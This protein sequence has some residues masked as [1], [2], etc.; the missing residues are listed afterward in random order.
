MKKKTI[1]TALLALVGMTAMAQKEI[2]WQNPSA[3]MGE[4]SA[5][6]KV[7]KVELKETETV[8]HFSAKYA[9]H[10]WIRFAKESFLRTPDGKKY[11]VTSGAKTIEGESDLQLDS[12]F[13]M[14]DSGEAD[15]ALH[16]K[17][18]PLDTKE[19]DFIEGYDEG[20][21]RFWNICDE[22]NKK[23]LEIPADW[24][25][26][27]YAKDETLPAAKINKGVAT[28]KVKM[29][30]YKPD[31]KMEFY[32][33]G[34]VPLESTE[35]MDKLFPFAD[36]GTLKVEIPLWLT[37]EVT[38]GVE[39]IS[40]PHIMI[41]PGQET[42]ILMKVTDDHRPFLA[43]KGFL[44]KT[45]MDLVDA[46]DMHKSFTDD[47]ETFLKV[48]ECKTPDERLRCLTDIFNQ[49]IAAIEKTKYTT[50]AKDLLSM[51]V[52][53]N[54][55]RWTHLFASTF[56]QYQVGEDGKV[57]RTFENFEEN[58]KKCMD[59]LPLSG[60]AAAYSWKYLNEPASPCSLAFWYTTIDNF[61]KNA[62]EKNAYNVELR[63]IPSVLGSYDKSIAD[64]MLKDL[65]FEDCKDVV[66]E[67]LVEQEQIVRQ[68]TGQ[69]SIFYQTYDDVAPENILQT[70]LD[71]YKGKAVLIDIWATWCGPC[72]YGHKVMAPMKEEMKGKNIQ[73]VYITSPSSPL[74]T[75]H[76]M[77]KDIDGDHYY[78]TKEQYN[79]I[80]SKYDS[81]G[82]P[83]YAIYNTLGEQTY[84]N[85]GFP[86]LDPIKNEIKKALKGSA[87][88][89]NF[90]IH[91]NFSK[92]AEAMS[93]QG[94]SFD[95]VTLVNNAIPEVVAKES[96]HDGVFTI[97][98]TVDKPYC[99]QLNISIS[100]EVNGEVKRKNSRLPIIIEPGEI[101]F[102]GNSQMPIIQ[103]T[104]L[105]DVLSDVISK[106]NTPDFIEKAKDLLIQHKD[107]AVAIPLLLMLD[108]CMLEPDTLLALI[109]QLSEDSQHH[110]PVAKVKEKAEFL[111]TRPKEGDMFKDFAVDY[112]GTTTH[113]SDYVG[114]GKY[115]LVDFWASWCGPCRQEI[116]NLVA[117]YKKYK[118]KDFQMLGVAA[119]DNP[120][121]SLKAID[122]MQIPYPQIL[123]SQKIATDLYG[124]EAIPETILFAPDGTILA[125]GLR[126]EK[127]G[128]KL[129]EIF[130]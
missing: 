24:K 85:I 115:V 45:N 118:D 30:G 105:N 80:L 41:A 114:R 112:D 73:F 44:A 62:K 113:L 81:D 54:Y 13:W 58:Y 11:V 21:F 46:Y 34:F 49:R 9:P 15:L 120:E 52:E 128:K 68:L 97:K 72:R 66:R 37:R 56:C 6:F 106:R 100:S 28:I 39:G 96:I 14:P 57:Y 83:T 69:E 101:Q 126:G 2:V 10:H 59:M 63:K 38:I 109:S 74:K 84:K 3:F 110:P 87:Q 90:T 104:P 103:G 43:F 99:A 48:R 89:N 119:Q 36:D 107:D 121:T 64:T 20:A 42:S 71:R 86:G 91:G 70:I 124:I 51:T 26:V 108:G 19:M 47:D 60:E 95:S 5:E 23:K 33:G 7:T 67:Y 78:L 16:F 1:I 94:L 88:S 18:V 17:P 111:L 50:A 117:L 75:W 40:Y 53:E 125:R 82:I 55:T 31:M 77:I 65:A 127:I 130:E 116:P 123:N 29:L 79:Y 22:S 25:D 129:A 32:V 92:V 122:E 4:S 76:E 93:K 98:G 12:L 102:D 8:L 35:Q 61:D 27:K